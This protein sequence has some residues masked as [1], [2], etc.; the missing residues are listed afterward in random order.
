MQFSFDLNERLAIE[1]KD[2]ILRKDTILM[3]RLDFNENI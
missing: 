3:E 1:R 2:S